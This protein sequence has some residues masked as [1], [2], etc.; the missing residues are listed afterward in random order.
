MVNLKNEVVQLSDGSRRHAHSGQSEV[1]TDLRCEMD[2]MAVIK[3]VLTRSSDLK[4]SK[5]VDGGDVSVEVGTHCAKG[6]AT[7]LHVQDARQGRKEEH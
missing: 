3:A 1:I 2:N 6:S 7:V 5:L 4:K